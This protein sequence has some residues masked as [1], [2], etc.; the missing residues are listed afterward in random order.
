MA[1][2]RVLYNLHKVKGFYLLAI[3]GMLVGLLLLEQLSPLKIYPS[4]SRK[5]HLRRSY[6]DG[7]RELWFSGIALSDNSICS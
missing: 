3:V 1:S 2:V 6:G 4:S 7:Y 5:H